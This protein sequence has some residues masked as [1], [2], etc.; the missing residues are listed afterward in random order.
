MDFLNS[1]CRAWHDHPAMWQDREVLVHGDATPANFFF[2]DGP[3]VIT[4]DLERAA[5]TDRLFDLG[6][7]TAELRHFFFRATGDPYAAEPFIGHFL[8]EYCGRF[9]DRES[10]FRSITARLPFYMGLNLLR[11]ARNT[12][13]D[14]R[15]RR[16]LVEAAQTCLDRRTP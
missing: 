6:R 12:Y 13:L 14:N 15:Y 11:I 8:W 16:Q 7:L 1:L 5:R 9:P 10:A 3:H 4:F 2:G